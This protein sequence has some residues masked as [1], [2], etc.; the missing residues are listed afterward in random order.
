MYLQDTVLHG[1]RVSV[2]HTYKVR[3]M[4]LQ[5]VLLYCILYMSQGK[6]IESTTSYTPAE[7]VSAMTDLTPALCA[8]LEK[9][10]AFFQVRDSNHTHMVM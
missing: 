2:S 1:V 7:L 6:A 3:N 10:S 9:N 5:V 8:Q 4:Y